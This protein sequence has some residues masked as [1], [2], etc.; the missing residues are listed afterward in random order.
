MTTPAAYRAQLLAEYEAYVRSHVWTLEEATVNTLYQEFID[1]YQRIA[2]Q[3]LD[4]WQRYGLGETWS[5]TDA[6]YRVRTDYLLSQISQI[7]YELSSATEQYAFSASLTAF[8]AGMFGRAWVMDGVLRA[9]APVIIPLIPMQAIVQAVQVPYMGSTFIDR[10][11][12]TRDEFIRLI[13]QSI[14]QSQIEGDGIYKAIKRLAERL[15]VDIGRRTTAARSANAGMFNRIEMIARTEILRSSNLGAIQIYMANQ[16][17]LKG[18]EWLATNDERTCPICGR[19]DGRQ[20]EFKSN[21]LPPPAH[22]MCR[23]SA[24]PVLIDSALEQAIVGTRQTYSEWAL[25]NGITAAQDGGIFG[26]RGVSAPA[27]PLIQG[28]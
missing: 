16:D 27:S 25:R 6:T 1:A 21:Q 28:A 18:W 17:V 22:P 3:L 13:R 23:C 24:T 12:N 5:A 11:A 15:G 8:E 20:F 2:A 7:L 14:V 10:F 9:D 4:I 26:L 19:L